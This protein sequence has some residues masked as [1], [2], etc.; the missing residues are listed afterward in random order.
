MKRF[1]DHRKNL[2][3]RMLRDTVKPQHTIAIVTL[4]LFSYYQKREYKSLTE[5]EKQLLETEVRL[6]NGKL[7]ENCRKK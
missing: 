1:R 5:Y 4:S 3:F 6:G 7:I 2:Y